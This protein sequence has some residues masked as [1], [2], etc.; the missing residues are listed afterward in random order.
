MNMYRVYYKVNNTNHNGWYLVQAI[1]VNQA[2]ARFTGFIKNVTV[3]KIIN[4]K[5]RNAL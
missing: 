2:E 4:H 1:N 3:T 5:K